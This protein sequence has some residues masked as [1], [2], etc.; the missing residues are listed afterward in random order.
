MKTTKRIIAIVLAALMLAMMIPF[1]ASA[2]TETVTFNVDCDKEGFVFTVYQLAT[3]DVE[4][5]KYTKNANTSDSI[6]SIITAEDGTT[7]ALLSAC[8]Q[9]TTGFGESVDTYT[10]SAAGTAKAISVPSGVYYIKA[11]TMPST[12]KSVTNSIVALPYY[13]DGKTKVSTL[14]PEDGIVEGAV[15]NNTIHLATKVNAGGTEVTKVITNS[16][17]TGVTTYTTAQLGETVNFKLTASVVGSTDYHLKRYEIKDTMSA[18]LTFGSVTEVKLTGGTAADKVLGTDDYTV[19]PATGGQNFTVSLD[20]TKVLG[21]DA[22]YGYTNVEVL[23]NATLN[24]N[25][26]VGSA[27]NTNQDKLEYTNANDVDG[28][29]DGPVVKVFTFNLQVKKV[30]ADHQEKGLNGAKFKV[31]AT[32]ADAEN[33]ANAIDEA[34]TATVNSVDGIAQFKTFKFDANKKYYV[35]ETEAPAGYNLNSYVY[36]VTT[37]AA[38]FSAAGALT[39]PTDGMLVYSTAIPN[40]KSELPQ[41]GG[42]GTLMFT[43]IGGALVL[44]AGALFVIIMKKRSS[45]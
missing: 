36:E 30:D 35:K 44:L 31:Y 38:Q 28:E 40:T 4:T 3:M 2:A 26:V 39:S 21:D 41:T 23:C 13:K 10:S 27:G 12:V 15:S 45:K 11:T 20:A 25:A 5:G 33:D 22:F 7:A 37:P 32:K 6:Y 29:K 14:Q 34:V 17:F 24:E 43:I 1:A 16:K 19:T 8:D 18:G 9:A 42:A